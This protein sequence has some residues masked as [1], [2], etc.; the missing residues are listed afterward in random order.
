[1]KC[2]N[3]NEEFT[4][5]TVVQK[6][7]CVQCRR[8]YNSTHKMD[9]AYPSITFQCRHCGK[10]VVTEGGSKDKRTTFCSHRCEK[11]YWKHPHYENPYTMNTFS[12]LSKYA[13]Y[14]RMTNNE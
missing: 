13:A 5:L 3:C 6:Y 9:D 10:K 14:E 8:M 7:C 12:S 1:M 11:N 2:L 4:P